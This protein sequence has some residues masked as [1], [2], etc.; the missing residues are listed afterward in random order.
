MSEMGLK[1]KFII[2][3]GGRTGS[4]AL[5][6]WLNSS[7]YI[8]CHNEVFLAYKN[9]SIDSFG[10]YIANTLG[11]PIFQKIALHWRIAGIE[12][13][14]ISLKYVDS[15]MKELFESK[16]FSAPWE[17]LSNQESFTRNENFNI[18]KLV[19]FKIGYTQYQALYG[20]RKWIRENDVYVIQLFRRNLLKKH[21]SKMMAD[22]T[23][24][25][26]SQDKVNNVK[27]NLN[28]P[29]AFDRIK[30]AEEYD[31]V[32]TKELHKYNQR[33]LSMYYED[34]LD[35][36]NRVN[37]SMEVADFFE[38]DSSMF[39]DLKTSL[40]KLNPNDLEDLLENYEEVHRAFSKT[41]YAHFLD[42]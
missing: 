36:D 35:I 2:T 22:K 40:K 11:K 18:E 24:V 1:K 34:F 25:W 9:S 32:F 17:K 39:L 4:T 12:G 30:V 21:V 27:L 5:V 23:S 13:N 6:K 28:I 19:G 20:A 31:L 16:S 8:R 37:F 41:K 7:P 42:S 3:T 15:F 33:I 38:E 14:P 10:Y 26:H 29:F